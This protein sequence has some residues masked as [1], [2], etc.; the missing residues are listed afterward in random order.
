MAAAKILRNIELPLILSYE[1]SV[2]I[3]KRKLRLGNF[4][5]ELMII[6]LM[7]CET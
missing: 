2:A 1:I 4:C 5:D 3:L 6:Q 7:F